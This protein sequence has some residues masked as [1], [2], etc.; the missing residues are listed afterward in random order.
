MTPEGRVKRKVTALLKTFEP[1]LYYHMPVVNGMGRPTLD[2]IGCI[3]GKFFAI[4][5]K[6]EGKEPTDRQR[7]TMKE[8]REAGAVVFLIVGENDPELNNLRNFLTSHSIT[9]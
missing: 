2:Y 8:M 3:N 1:K 5:T 9:T 6:A 4:E 7:L